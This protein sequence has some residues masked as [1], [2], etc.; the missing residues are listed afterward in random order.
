MLARLLFLLTRTASRVML[1]KDKSPRRAL[2]SHNPKWLRRGEELRNR[3]GQELSEGAT[4]HHTVAH[5][6][7]DLQSPRTVAESSHSWAQYGTTSGA[8]VSRTLFP[9]SMGMGLG[10][11]YTSDGGALRFLESPQA[12]P[13]SLRMPL[14]DAAAPAGA[15]DA[16]PP[17]HYQQQQQ[18]VSVTSGAFFQQ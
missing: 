13:N 8:A 10:G 14:P 7:A 2:H 4:P 16:R 3:S 18:S 17:H 12:T 9:A 15:Y 1:G 6:D 5:G 11:D